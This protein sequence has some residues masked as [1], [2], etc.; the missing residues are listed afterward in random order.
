MICLK[1]KEEVKNSLDNKKSLITISEDATQ[2]EIVQGL[3]F[4]HSTLSEEKTSDQKY[5]LEDKS[6]V[7][8]KRVTERVPNTFNRGR[9]DAE[10][11]QD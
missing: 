5:Q 2:A 9:R 4:V 11:K 8:A 7:I 1:T 6:R 10:I 3:D